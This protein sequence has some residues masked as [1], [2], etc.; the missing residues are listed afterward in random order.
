MRLVPTVWVLVGQLPIGRGGQSIL[1][2]YD[3][4]GVQRVYSIYRVGARRVATILCRLL[5][6]IVLYAL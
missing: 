1:F 6:L 2:R 3:V 4:C 5:R